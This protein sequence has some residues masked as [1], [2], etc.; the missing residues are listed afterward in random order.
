M[1]LLRK[2]NKNVQIIPDNDKTGLMD[3]LKVSRKG[4]IKDITV[5]VDIDH[6]FVGDLQ[7]ALTT[8]AGKE[9]MLHNRQGG[10][11]E[12][13]K[14]EFSGAIMEDL[15]GDACHGD[16]TI[17]VKDMAVRDGGTLNSW[18]VEMKCDEKVKKS[19]IIIPDNDADGLLSVQNC[20]LSG[21]VTSIKAMVD[22][23]HPYIGDLM[24]TLFAP[25]GKS[26]IL[27]NR[28]GGNQKNLKK[29]YS[30]EVQSL[31]G[32][33]TKGQWKLQMKDFAPRDNGRLKHWK[34][35]FSYSQIDDLKKVEGIG[36]KIEGLLNAAGIFSFS[37]LSVASYDELKG[38]LTEAGSRYQTHDPQTWGQQA[39]M[40]AKGQWDELKQWQDELDGGK[41]K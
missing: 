37:R 13:L 24:V 33:G 29:T 28:Q 18:A 41:A 15:I 17:Q 10:R 11:T 8:P 4:K 1:I 16:W 14:E 34:V 19:E 6:P 9:I 7:V 31:I 35:E 32:E 3:T 2:E 38:I 30:D 26:V 22:I 23:E 12:G 20:R 39:D 21:K 36:P 27:H 25:S 40:A 5:S